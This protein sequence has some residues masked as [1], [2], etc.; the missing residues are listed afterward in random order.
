MTRKLTKIAFDSAIFFTFTLTYQINGRYLHYFYAR[1]KKFNISR[2]LINILA[3]MCD[4]IAN[5]VIKG[6][7]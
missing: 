1:C 3:F 5:D 4:W 7:T 6:N 2:R